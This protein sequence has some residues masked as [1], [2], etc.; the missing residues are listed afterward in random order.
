MTLDP[1]ATTRLLRDPLVRAL[2]NELAAK[3]S[4]L[5]ECGDSGHIDLRRVPLPA[6]ALEALRGWLGN[7]EI[8]ASVR[9]LG[10]TKIRETG[11][12]GVWWITQSRLSGETISEHLEISLA[13]ALLAADVRDLPAALAAMRERMTLLDATGSADPR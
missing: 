4:S 3:L 13:P 2:L 9:A 5:A 1:D 8:E 7:G 11:V 6:G 12:A 10:L